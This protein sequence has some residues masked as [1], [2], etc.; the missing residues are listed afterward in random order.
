LS[1]ILVGHTAEITA[2][3]LTSEGMRG[4]SSSLDNTIKMWDLRSGKVTKTI[5][6]VGKDVLQVCVHVYRIGCSALPTLL[7]DTVLTRI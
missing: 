2:I 5:P 3:G 7:I 4:V 6:G 1:D